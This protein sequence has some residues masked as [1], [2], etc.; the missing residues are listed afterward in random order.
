MTHNVLLAIVGLTPQVVTETLYH[1]TQVRKVTIHEVR[2]VTTTRGARR[3]EE[4]LLAEPDGALWQFCREYGIAPDTIDLAP[5]VVL[6]D[7]RGRPLEDIRTAAENA[8]AGDQILRVVAEYTSSPRTRLFCSLAGGRKTMSTFAGFAMQ[9]LGRAQDELLHVLVR[10]PELESRP[11]FFYP[12]PDG[13]F[14]VRSR[15]GTTVRVPASRIAVDCASVP[16][17][18]LREHLPPDID[19]TRT[20]YGDLVALTQGRLDLASL[21]P[22]AVLDLRTRVLHVSWKGGAAQLQVTPTTAALL[23]F[24]LA[25]DEKLVVSSD[26]LADQIEELWDQRNRL[27]LRVQRGRLEKLQT[28]DPKLERFR[29]AVSKWKARLR[30]SEL[31]PRLAELLAIKSR[32]RG[33]LTEYFCEFPAKDFHIRQ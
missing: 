26:E 29:Q 8:A 18:R 6:V 10:P 4:L 7:D 24:F 13:D 30:K 25:G 31:D 21:K 23:H 27:L 20:R 17:V 16:F 32:R 15:D 3:A 1:L 2:L 33:A 14:L 11:D 19:P 22:S 12:P 9:L 5:T 28:S